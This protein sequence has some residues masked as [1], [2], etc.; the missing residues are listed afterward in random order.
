VVMGGY[1][2]SRLRQ[3]MLGGTTRTLLERM[4]LPILFSH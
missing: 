3:M 1:S 2:H 4:S